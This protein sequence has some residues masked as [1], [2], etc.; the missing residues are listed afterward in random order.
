MRDRAPVRM[1]IVRVVSPP[2]GGTL[3]GV[4]LVGCLIAQGCAPLE[5]RDHA[6]TP[7]EIPALES[8]LARQPDLVPVLVRLGAAYRAA[9]Q[10]AEASTVLERA[11]GI[12]P[13]EA[14][15]VLYLGLTYEELGRPTDA[16]RLY[17]A[18]VELGR[19][20]ELRRWVAGR[21]PALRRQELVLAARDAAAR[22][23]ELGETAPRARHVAV[24]PFQYTGDDP[25]YR[26]LG[27]ALAELLVTDLSQT[28]RLTVLERMQ[29][30]LL[31]DEMRLAETGL[32]DTETGARSGRLLGAEH[33]VQGRLGAIAEDLQLEAAVVRVAGA[34]RVGSTV[35]ERDAA[36]RLFDSQK[37]LA[38]G[39]YRALG[40]ELTPA[41]R[42]R[43]LRQ[44]T[45]N[46]DA[47]I[48][49][50]LGLEA[51]DGGDFPTAAAHF[52][53][54][55]RLDPGFAEARA[56]LDRSVQ[57]SAAAEATPD[58]LAEAGIVELA[59]VAP[60]GL[61]LDLGEL[62]ALDALIPE[63]LVRDAVAEARG[64]DRFG[65]R[66]VLDIILRRP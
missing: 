55:A 5:P 33:V 22:E 8:Q 53:R 40:I 34:D 65:R 63:P 14:A 58:R 52:D 59:F 41:E 46:L 60:A 57:A 47:L 32:V 54:A 27:R 28:D 48:A 12:D 35:T 13:A 11:L 10:L 19:S 4:A 62:Y 23:A 66:A 44:A 51:L 1:T 7:A 38:V 30:Q 20:A 24:F 64:D 18:Y 61:A 15:G 16:V 42:E 2:T 9:G 50:G 21:I 31:L 17:E 45:D 29:V 25:R 56:A 26:P 3:A 39:L 37:R 43:V 6:P 49:F 36:R